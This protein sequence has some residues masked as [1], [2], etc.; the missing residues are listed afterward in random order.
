MQKRSIAKQSST[1]RD[2]PKSQTA[3]HGQ[4]PTGPVPALRIADS[5]WL[6]LIVF[7]RLFMVFDLF[8]MLLIFIDA[9]Y[10]CPSCW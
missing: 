6:D 4:T 1:R 10:R 2:I 5:G 8:V 9:F 3:D 7:N